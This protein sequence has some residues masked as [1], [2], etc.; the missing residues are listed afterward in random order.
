MSNWVSCTKQQCHA[1]INFAQKMFAKAKSR[2]LD[3]KY[4][5]GEEKKIGLAQNFAINKKSTIS[6]RLKF[7][8]HKV[9][10]R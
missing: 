2:V 8:Q 5:E 3:N 10:M 4:V 1:F 9:L 6:I 7:Q